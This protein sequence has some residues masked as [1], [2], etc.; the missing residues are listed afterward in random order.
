MLLDTV[1][2]TASSPPLGSL[3]SVD[4]EDENTEPEHKGLSERSQAVG[5][6]LSLLLVALIA[7]LLAV[8]LHK[9][10]RR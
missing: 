3:S 7:C 10:E 9:K 4:F 1:P 6:V 2:D 5:A 8:L